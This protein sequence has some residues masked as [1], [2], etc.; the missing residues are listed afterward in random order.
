MMMMVNQAS[1]IFFFDSICE[2]GKSSKYSL[3]IKIGRNI[4]FMVVVEKIDWDQVLYY[5]QAKLF[6]N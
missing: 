1:I 3:C 6:S 2:V 5:S 4:L